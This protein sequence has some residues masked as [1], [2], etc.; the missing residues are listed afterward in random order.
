MS[1]IIKA[2]LQLR[3]DTASNAEAKNEVLLDREPFI[4]KDT[5]K[6]KIGDGVTHYNDLDYVTTGGGNL[7]SHVIDMQPGEY[8]MD[9]IARINTAGDATEEN[10]YT[11]NFYNHSKTIDWSRFTAK[12]PFPDNVYLNFVGDINWYNN[13]LYYVGQGFDDDILYGYT[14]NKLFLGFSF[15][16]T[17]LDGKIKLTGFPQDLS[18]IFFGGLDEN[19]E[20]IEDYAHLT[21]YAGLGSLGLVRVNGDDTVDARNNKLYKK[22]NEVFVDVTPNFKF[23]NLITYNLAGTYMYSANCQNANFGLANCQ[24]AYFSLANCQSAY[25][26]Y[27][28]CQSANFSYANC[29]SAYFGYANCQ[30]AYFGSANCQSANFSYANCQSAYFSYANLKNTSWNNVISIANANFRDADLTGAINLPDRINTKVKFIA[31]CGSGN[32]NAA[33]KWIDGTNILS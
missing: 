19:T 17:N 3:G 8:L 4:E 15:D 18:F 32:V 30:S 28:N 7:N 23:A 11:I 25:F 20:Q 27:A 21:N 24:G 10:P 33:T 31:E 6:I 2:R 9:I 22:I 26:G 29:Q 12:I 1:T 5:K 13:H 14:N 16:K